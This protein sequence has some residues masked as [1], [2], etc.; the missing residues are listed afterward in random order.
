MANTKQEFLKK[1][2]AAKEEDVG[3]VIE[4]GE[5]RWFEGKPAH[6]EKGFGAIQI[7]ESATI[8]FSAEDLVDSESTDDRDTCRVGLNPEATVLL[9][10]T[11][12]VKLDG[13]DCS[14]EGSAET[15]DLFNR[16]SVVPEIEINGGVV[17]PIPGFIHP[18]VFQGRS[19]ERACRNEGGDPLVC[20]Q[21]GAATE[22]LCRRSR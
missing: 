5:L 6:A 9:T 16:P 20:A 8:S 10:Q 22:A 12:V 21:L 4:R 18:C 2:Q 3:S 1:C 19:V 7:S 11:S 15:P 13:C 17:D 14:G